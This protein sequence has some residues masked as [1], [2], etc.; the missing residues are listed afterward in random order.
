MTVRGLFSPCQGRITFLFYVYSKLTFFY[1]F[2]AFQINP[3]LEL[4]LV[5]L[6]FCFFWL[7]GRWLWVEFGYLA[8][9]FECCLCLYSSDVDLVIYLLVDL[10]EF[11]W[12]LQNAPS[13]PGAPFTP[14]CCIFS[15]GAAC[16]CVRCP[17][18]LWE[19][20][21][22]CWGFLDLL[23]HLQWCSWTL[24]H[25]WIT[26]MK[27]WQSITQSSINEVLNSLYISNLCINFWAVRHFL[28]FM[29]LHWQ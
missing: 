17:C 28:F 19:K 11:N 7:A 10:V 15:K 25:S 3:S 29:E 6:H 2:V 9:R 27:L 18:W 1:F 5:T 21:Q 16:I 24:S 14:Y 13:S 22:V 8:S 12:K 20:C 26:A 4:L 23:A